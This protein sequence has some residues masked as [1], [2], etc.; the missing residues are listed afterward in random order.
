MTQLLDRNGSQPSAKRSQKIQDYFDVGLHELRP[1]YILLCDIHLYFPQNK[2]FMVW[3]KTNELLTPKFFTRYEEKGITKVWISIHDHLNWLEY[4]NIKTPPLESPAPP[5]ILAD[6]TAPRTQ[7]GEFL[8]QVMN[9]A[10]I[11]DKVK[12]EVV[13]AATQ[14]LLSKAGEAKTIEEQ[15]K[16]NREM[17]KTVQDVLDLTAKKTTTA[18]AEIWKLAR[19]DATL[20][21][22]VNVATYA[23]IFSMA[24]KKLNPEE[25][26][27][28]ASASL[29]HD[30][31]LTQ[32]SASEV[33][34][35]RAERLLPAN[36]F[37]QKHYETHITHTL[38]LLKK[39][40]H[41]PANTQTDGHSDKVSSDFPSILI[42]Q[43]HEKFD[44]TGYPQ[45][46]SG[47]KVNESAQLLQMADV[48]DNVASG[49]W[50]GEVR[51]LTDALNLLVKLEKSKTFP[52]FFNPE[53]FSPVFRWIRNTEPDAFLD[54]VSQIVKKQAVSL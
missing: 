27:Q 52:E 13:A 33:R 15:K 37:A 12:A 31:G 19:V 43:H 44:G 21:H 3:R 25:L 35:S 17:K 6:E 36:A 8:A 47:F 28:L 24:F 11:P 48:I 46:I 40:R 26:S 42:D 34:L 20:D 16:I 53:I 23:V 22:A 45:G 5:P 32:V 51:T 49:R 10:K 54:S 14:E 7:T 30:I 9:S 38:N 29:L 39:Y 41:E 4:L 18:V 1:G 50:D 2:H